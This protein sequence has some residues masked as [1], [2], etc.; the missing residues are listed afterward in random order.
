MMRWLV[1]ALALGAALGC[2]KKKQAAP[3][4]PGQQ[5]ATGAGATAPGGG[6]APGPAPWTDTTT[7]LWAFAPPD[8]AFGLVIG[9]GV[10]E[11]A[12]VATKTQIDA[13][14]TSAWAEQMM[15]AL[16]EAREEL[17]FDPMDPAGWAKIGIDLK[18]GVALFV[19]P[20]AGDEE[21][22][23]AILPV[24]D[25]AAFRKK[26]EGKV[27]TIDGKEID[28][29]DEDM[30]CMP[31][32]E[33][34]LCAKTVADIEAAAKAH[35]S[36]LAEKVKALP[37]DG[38]GDVEIYADLERIPDA[39]E[40]LAELGPVGSIAAAGGAARMLPDGIVVRGWAKG[41]MTGD[42]GRALQATAPRPEF[43][44][45][46]GAVSLMRMVI[47]PKLTFLR[48]LDDAMP[49]SNVDLRK[50]LFEQLTGEI[51]A[52][53]AGKGLAAGAL[54]LGLEDGERVKTALKNLC[55]MA[56]A[57]VAKPGSPVAKLDVTER[58]CKAELAFG[59]LEADLGALPNLPLEIGVDG[60]VLALWVGEVDLGKLKASG[61]SEAGSWETQQMLGA[62]ASFLMWTRGLD[63]DVTL[64]PPKLQ[65]MVIASKE[66]RM[67]IDGWTHAAAT[68]Y[69]IGAAL[70]VNPDGA[71]MV[72]RVTTFAGDPAEAIAAY[73]A[74]L[75]KRRGGD[76]E[77]ARAALAEVAKKWP[78]SKSGKRAA[79][80]TR[81]E[82]PL[83]GPAGGL[84]GAGVAAFGMFTT[85]QVGDDRKPSNVEPGFGIEGL[86][87]LDLAPNEPA[88]PQKTP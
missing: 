24:V 11:A 74:A 71:S 82:A 23:L 55:G 9:D 37:K 50:D 32:A 75:D 28:R 10:G 69:E 73:R 62:P 78:E 81:G 87:G 44:L 80:A 57:F 12:R 52:V 46:G 65:E 13:V 58:G 68:I 79:L 64:L 76:G 6:A 59:P 14:A 51:A 85:R 1:V 38:R 36:K 66:G 42:V 77:G 22:P 61:P 27:E 21:R 4:E 20:G 41:A 60:K 83:M 5:P 30:V 39:K 84:V 47:P 25:R 72:F 34:Y 45:R 70:A 19:T 48:E 15:K 17:G 86:G 88:A 7:A 18:K 49:A 40:A 29:I 53:T 67:L 26:A 56:A 54:L 63:V 3:G 2:G 43:D 31:K 8:A 16:A 35:E 33:R